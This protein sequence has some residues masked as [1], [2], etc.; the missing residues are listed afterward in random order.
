MARKGA[1]TLLLPPHGCSQA[2]PF[3][4]LSSALWRLATHASV[5]ASL[6]HSYASILPQALLPF[7]N[8]QE[9]F[10]QSA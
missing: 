6:P 10:P 5:W 9:T 2:L 8:A 7:A 1:T 3:V 4:P